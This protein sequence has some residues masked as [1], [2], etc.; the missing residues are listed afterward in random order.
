VSS[1]EALFF[2]L[3]DERS[4]RGGAEAVDAAPRGDSQ[5]PD[6]LERVADR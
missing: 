4:E 2:A 6:S 5:L 1:L 3:T